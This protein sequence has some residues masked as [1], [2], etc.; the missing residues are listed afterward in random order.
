MTRKRFNNNAADTLNGAITD[1]ATTI[2]LNDASEFPTP[3]TNEIAY[4][5][6]DDGTNVEI[7]TYTG[8]STNDLTGVTRGVDGTSGTAFADAT[9]VEQRAISS[10]LD[11]PS[12]YFDVNQNT[13]G[14]SVGDVV[15]LSG[16]STYTKAQ[17]DSAANAE[18]AGVVSAVAGSNDFT[19]TTGG[20]IAGLSGLTA[21]TVYFLDPST[22]GAVT[23]TEPSTANQVSKPVYI[24]DSTTSAIMLPHRGI[25]VGGKIAVSD[26]ADGTDGELITW[27]ASGSPTTVAVGTS[28]HVLTSNGAGAAPTFQAASGGTTATYFFANTTS[29]TS[30]SDATFTKMP[31]DN[32]VTD[33]NSD[34]DPTTNYRH[35]PTIAGKYLYG[36]SVNLSSVADQKAILAAV[37]KNG[38]S[39]GANT[40][41]TSGSGNAQATVY[42]VLDMNG[43]TDYAEGYVYHEHGSARNLTGIAANNFFFGILV[44]AT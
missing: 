43:S 42:F 26:L 1:S 5:T 7:I 27:D 28:G 22:A 2:T 13:H 30:I 35:T 40:I 31:Y 8:I 29:T 36:V 44:E 16:A 10:A 6:I 15:R 20:R 25:V 24:A 9:A 4:A 21:N 23:A 32:E 19:L 37:Y 3:G 14:F 11:T 12:I 34:Y 17:A 41:F 33:E 38:S 39:Q 18:V